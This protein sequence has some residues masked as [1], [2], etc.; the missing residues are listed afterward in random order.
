MKRL[1]FIVFACLSSGLLMANHFT[2]ISGP[3]E[4]NFA[5][6]GSLLING[7]R[8]ESDNFEIGVFCGE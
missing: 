3:Y 8:P 7:V 2:P 1:L 5:L 4:N 6:V